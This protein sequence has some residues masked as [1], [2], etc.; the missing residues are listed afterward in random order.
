MLFWGWGRRSRRLELSQAQALA[1]TYRYFHLFFIFTV[2]FG[3]SYSLLTLTEHGW[4]ASRIGKEQAEEVLAG[5]SLQPNPWQRFSL[6][7]FVAVIALLVVV[8]SLRH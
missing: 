6:Y 4:A 2:T 3:G 5:R 8:N 1:L 7:G